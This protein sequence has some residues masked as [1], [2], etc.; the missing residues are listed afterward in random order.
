MPALALRKDE[1]RGSLLRMEGA[2]S[3]EVPP[4]LLQV[5]HVAGEDLHDIQPLLYFING[6]HAGTDPR[7]LYSLSRFSFSL[8]NKRVHLGFV[9]GS[10]WF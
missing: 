9:Q 5:G 1:E 10:D 2:H 6:V 8:T 7:I 3:F 4:A